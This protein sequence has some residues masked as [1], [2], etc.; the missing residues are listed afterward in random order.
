MKKMVISLIIFIAALAILWQTFYLTPYLDG[1][2]VV[3]YNHFLKQYVSSPL[4]F[5]I[6]MKS[7]LYISFTL[8]RNIIPIGI[9]LLTGF[10]ISKYMS[11]YWIVFAFS[12]ML[13]LLDLPQLILDSATTMSFLDF[14][15]IGILLFVTGSYAFPFYA[16]LGYSLG[17]KYL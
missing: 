8:L 1:I 2:G 15:L 14:S 13:M 5:A 4:L 17:R 12:V 16:M 7:Y 9:F 10:V 6:L 3:P 11:S